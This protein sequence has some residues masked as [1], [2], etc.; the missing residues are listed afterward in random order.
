[1]NGR[2]KLLLLPVVLALALVSAAGAR[3]HSQQANKTLIISSSADP[4]LL[5]GALIS[6]GESLRI[7]DQIFNSLVG[8]KLG[9]SAV[10]PELAKSWKATN[11]GKKWTFHLRHGVRFSDGTRFNAAAVCFNFNRWYNLPGPMQNINVSYYWQTVFL[12]FHHPAAGSPGPSKSLYRGCKAKGK[13]TAI[14][15]LSH[16][17]SS[18]ISALGLPNFGIASPKALKK[19][20]ADA[21]TV[22]A[23]GVF[24]PAG[25]F[26]TRHPVGTGPWMLKSWTPNVKLVLVPNPLYWGKDKPKLKQVIYKPIPD[27]AARLQALQSGEVDAID[28]VDPADF[29]TV[30]KDSKLKLLRRPTST[31]GYFGLNQ[32]KPP[33]NKL[34]V[35]Q[36]VA[37]GLNRATIVHA[38]YGGSGQLAN[39]F[40]PPSLVGWAKKGVPNYP[41]NPSKAKALLKGAGLTLPVP[42]TLA[43]PTNVSRPYMPDP[44]RNA[45]AFAAS[46][47]N[48][49]FKVT[50]TSAPWRPDYL[51]GATGGKWQTFLFGWIA[52]YYDPQDF[53]NVHFGSATPQFGLKDASLFKALAKADAEPNL[54]K[55]A[56]LYQ[57]ASIK[58]MKILPVV[59]YVWASAGT[60]AMKKKVRGYKVGPVG[61]VNEPWSL[62][63]IGK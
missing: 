16:P 33:M 29:G 17:S 28:Y 22:D 25:T 21:G 32:A 57:A 46:L 19:Y 58:V 6:D 44:Q 4:V 43:Y 52:D 63:S 49:G 18:V 35:R 62:V 13:Y 38:F 24:H 1:M 5:D 12:G 3:V 55:R 45:Q 34:A 20:K 47:D 11:H 59:P 2:R 48:S 27:N 7:T 14:I 36:A 9:G 40:L 53:L 23:T 37:Y 61:P 54:A 10:V 51:G 15:R 30:R 56:A 50:L 31:V 41:Y 60:L 26:S 42:I 8:F 39:Q